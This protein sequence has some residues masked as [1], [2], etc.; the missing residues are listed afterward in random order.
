MAKDTKADRINGAFSVI[1]I[2][3]ITLKAGSDDLALALD[4]LENMMA[5]FFERNICV[6][7]NFED[8]PNSATPCGIGRQFW[9]T[10][11]VLLAQRLLSDFGKEPTLALMQQIKSSA[12]F[13][14]SASAT[15]EETQYPSRMPRG[16]GNDLRFSR[17]Q[18]FYPQAVSAPNECATNRMFKGN[19]DDFVEHFDSKLISPETISTYT[20]E[21]D[22]GLTIQ[23]DSI[24]DS[25]IIYRILAD[26]N[27][28]SITQIVQVKIVVTTSTSRIIT[29][30]INFEI[31]TPDEIV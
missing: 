15:V 31:I 7:Y 29:R 3:G 1:K 5:E 12:S 21:A 17:W 11:E 6:N 18:R 10:S 20:I 13:L 26:D 14:S 25:D 8:E 24:S 2:S 28:S 4:R 19:V 22:T 30:M 16:S 23:S 9:Y 27:T